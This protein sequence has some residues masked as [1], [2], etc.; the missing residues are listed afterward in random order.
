MPK[1]WDQTVDAHRRAVRA[2]TVEAAA[3]LVREQGLRAVTMSEI[4]KRTGIGR[5]T[6]YKYFSDIDEILVAWHELQVTAHLE[7]LVLIK[8]GPGD[9]AARLRRILTRY[10]EIARSS[11]TPHGLDLPDL[12]GHEHA[13]AAE[14]RLHDLLGEL[15][16]DA[17][18][19]G[20]VRDDVAPAELAEYC[21]HALAA[22]AAL[23]SDDAVE[24]L[25][26]VVLAGLSTPGVSS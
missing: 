14:R 9:V 16:T 4:A 1:L 3:D 6:L 7:Q 24:R 26:T 2:A 15:L 17:V 12:H 20:A 11:R 18:R 19:S 8:D 21:R 22:A 25:V 13:V 23:P 10:A 5:A